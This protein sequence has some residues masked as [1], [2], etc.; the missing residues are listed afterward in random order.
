MADFD[1]LE[2]IIFAFPDAC[3]GPLPIKDDTSTASAVKEPVLL[4]GEIERQAKADTSRVM[5]GDLG[6]FTTFDT[7]ALRHAY[8]LPS[9]I[10]AGFIVEEQSFTVKAWNASDTPKTVDSILKENDTGTLL[11]HETTPFSLPGDCNKLHSLTIFKDGP[12]SQQ[13]TFTYTID[14]DM[15]VILVTGRRIEPFLFDNDWGGSYRYTPAYKTVVSTSKRF[16]EQ[17]RPLYETPRRRIECEFWEQSVDMQRLYNF[18]K[19]SNALTV[20]FPV[21]HE[22]LDLSSPT[23]QGES[24]LTFSNDFSDFTNLVDYTSFILMKD[25]DDPYALNEIKAIASMDTVAKTITLENTVQGAFVAGNTDVFPVALGAIRAD[26]Y[27]HSFQTD[28]I[29]KMG[30]KFEE[31]RLG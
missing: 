9:K 27:S 14:G 5:S 8:V 11:S 30:I 25:K 26:G 7:V 2:L 3:I 21:F 6:T 18:L 19:K 15:F 13:T 29:Q 1:G 23:I 12:P 31:L 4:V 16:V 17:R 10:D 20:G 28:N 22:F 24:I